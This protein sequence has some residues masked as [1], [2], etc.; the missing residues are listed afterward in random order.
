MASKSKLKRWPAWLLWIAAIV[1]WFWSPFSAFW[2]FLSGLLVF[3]ALRPRSPRHENR[4]LPRNV[5]RLRPARTEASRPP[6][7]ASQ[8]PGNTPDDTS[9]SALP[10]RHETMTTAMPSLTTARP[11]P[12]PSLE[13]SGVRP[14]SWREAQMAM[15]QEN[16]TVLAGLCV[17]ARRA[18]DCRS[19]SIF[20]PARD[21][22]VR[23]RMWDT[24]AKDFKGGTLIQPG[25]GLL[26]SLLK[27]GS[28]GDLYEFDLPHPGSRCEW[29]ESSETHTLGA[30]RFQIGERTGIIAADDERPS[31]FAR[32]RLEMLD[33]LA[34]TA[35]MLLERGSRLVWESRQKDAFAK[36]L[37]AVRILSASG[38]EKDVQEHLQEFLAEQLPEGS[39]LFLRRCPGTPEDA[40]VSWTSG[41]L[42]A[43]FED[44]PFSL[45]GQ[46]VLSQ[47]FARGDFMSRSLAPDSPPILLAGGEPPLALTRT[48]DLFFFPLR[49]HETVDAALVV[50]SPERGRI[51]L[52]LRESVELIASTAAQV[53]ARI[54]ADEE[55]ENLAT[56]DGLTGLVN[57]R[58]FQSG[59]HREILRARR[60]GQTLAFLLTDIDH[61]KNVNDTHGHQ[62][63]DIILR[64]VADIARAQVREELDIAARYGGEEF[65]FVL[66]GADA[67]AAMETA[68]RIR[69]A[70]EA[71]PADVGKPTPLGVTISVGVSVFPQDAKEPAELIKRADD[72]LYR[73]KNGGRNRIERALGPG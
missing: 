47:A 39:S 50:I 31:A 32:D 55:L 51:P 25:A 33:Q 5:P 68:E 72:A 1:A 29:Y 8:V 58:T 20:L 7:P 37:E 15:D 54:A 27:P 70:V 2:I 61:F 69:A 22:K 56:R 46:G 63:G 6:I 43:G 57:H 17:I 66:I 65:G 36:L 34:D 60:T 52:F 49:I 13:S 9:A 19:I 16:A 59:L 44:F 48:G 62:A 26:G 23:L 10:T 73:A 42:T 28:P 12:E 53:L 71:S 35:I 64:H 18:L 3:L 14:S 45:P 40:Q 11:A 24:I 4:K 30:I 67:Q 21:G 41:P 38:S